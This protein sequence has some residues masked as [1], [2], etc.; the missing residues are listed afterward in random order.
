[1]K[2]ISRMFENNEK[3]ERIQ[4]RILKGTDLKLKIENYL[5]VQVTF[6]DLIKLL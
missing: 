2:T 5:I 6:I 1:M 3:H 4:K